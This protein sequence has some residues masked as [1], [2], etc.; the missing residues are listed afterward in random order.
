MSARRYDNSHDEV[1]ACTKIWRC[2]QVLQE[3]Y[4]DRTEI[5]RELHDYEGL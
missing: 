1:V 4:A 5:L 3:G 2:I